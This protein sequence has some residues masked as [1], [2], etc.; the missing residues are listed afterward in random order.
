[1][2]KLV[3]IVGASIVWLTVLLICLIW[4]R[5]KFSRALRWFDKKTP[6]E[7]NQIILWMADNLHD[8]NFPAKVEDDWLST[9]YEFYPKQIKKGKHG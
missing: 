8:G 2:S 1:M 3:F 7:K 5:R 9:A 4:P 6:Q